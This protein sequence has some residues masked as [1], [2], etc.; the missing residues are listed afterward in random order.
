MGK[1]LTAHADV[2]CPHAG[3]ATIVVPPA[4]T[5]AQALVGEK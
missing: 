3:G 4:T 1:V 2:E 5:G